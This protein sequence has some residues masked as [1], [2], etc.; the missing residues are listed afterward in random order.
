MTVRALKPLAS[1][2]VVRYRVDGDWSEAELRH[3]REGVW[4]GVLPVAEVPDYRLLVT[5]GDHSLE[6]DDPYRF[7]PTLGEVDQHLIREGRHE[8]L[9]KVLGARVHHYE[10]PGGPDVT[11]TSFAVWAPRAYGVRLE[12]DFNSWDG[13][14]H[15][16]RQ[17]GESGVWELFVP[18]VGTGTRYKFI[19]LGADQ[20]WRE[21]A[22]PMAAWAEVPPNT[23]SMVFESRYSWGDQ[24]WM[25]ARPAKQPVA[26]PMSVYEVH[27]LVATASLLRRPRRG[28]G[29]LRQRPG[30]HPRR[31]HAGDA[32]PLRRVVGLPRDVLLRPRLPAR[33]A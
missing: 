23:S 26:E 16:M 18:A 3:E 33:H 29:R 7:L 28:A 30:I 21:K 24:E 19:I 6:V 27:L 9:W 14:E 25:Q 12:G 4:V 10:S 2:V 1:T 32:A 22:D 31:A 11:G 20:H 5:Y 8:Q 13:R 17:L 15:P